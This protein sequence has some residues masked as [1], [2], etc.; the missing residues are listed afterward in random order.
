MGRTAF[1][2]GGF[3]HFGL[4]N[5]PKE[6]RRVTDKVF[7]GLD[8]VRCCI[9][10]SIIFSKVRKEHGQHMREVFKRLEKHGLN[11]HPRKCKFF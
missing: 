11:I 3:Y 9:D 7:V 1:T 4:R 6:F 8:F 2:D 5:A 10:D